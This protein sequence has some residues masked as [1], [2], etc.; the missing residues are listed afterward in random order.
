MNIVIRIFLIHVARIPLLGE[1]QEGVK[2]FIK[3][4]VMRPSQCFGNE[5]TR[6]ARNIN[7]RL[8]GFSALKELTCLGVFDV[9]LDK[10]GISVMY[11]KTIGSSLKVMVCRG[12]II[13]NTSFEER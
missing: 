12:K 5:M 13:D 1:H 7:G 4:K 2:R 6:F 11:N 10:E 9:E 8:T 3:L